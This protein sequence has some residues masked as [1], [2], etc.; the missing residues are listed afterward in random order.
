MDPTS[1][2][3][4]ILVVQDN[5]DLS[6]FIT[7]MLISQDYDVLVAK[8]GK[9]FPDLISFPRFELIPLDQMWPGMSGVRVLKHLR[10]AKDCQ[11]KNPLT[12]TVP[13][14]SLI[15]DIDVAPWVGATANLPASLLE[16]RERR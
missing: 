10:F 8:N 1:A 2:E 4:H 9:E 6:E 7:Q 16:T 5:Q 14:K 13:A 12:I 3:N 15:D 11:I